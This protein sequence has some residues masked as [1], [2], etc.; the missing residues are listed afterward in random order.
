MDIGN[1]FKL[2]ATVSLVLFDDQRR[3][4]LLRRHGTGWLDGHYGLVGGTID[5]NEP[6]TQAMIREAQE[7]A[8]IILKPDLL[9]IVCV[10][11]SKHPPDRET[12]DFSFIA[13]Q[14][15]GTLNNNEPHKHDNIGF[16][17]FNQL[18]QPLVPHAKHVLANLGEG[19]HFHEWGWK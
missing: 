10:L 12:I 19:I 8:N 6:L 16:Y 18:P 2:M 11:H 1:R 14:F 7:E 13:H 15:E 5:G 9:R 17:P 3:I 4:L